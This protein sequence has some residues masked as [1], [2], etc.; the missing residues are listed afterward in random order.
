MPYDKRTTLDV[1]ADTGHDSSILYK[2]SNARYGSNKKD[3]HAEDQQQQ[4]SALGFTKKRALLMRE[5]TRS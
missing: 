2:L 4:R 5:S 1:K 3:G